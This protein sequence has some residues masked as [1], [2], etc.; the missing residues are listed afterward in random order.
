MYVNEE[1]HHHGMTVCLPNSVII[2]VGFQVVM[3]VSTTQLTVL[4]IKKAA[5]VCINSRLLAIA[6][7]VRVSAK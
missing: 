7:A 5:E 3:A 1:L 6:C 4:Y 2:F